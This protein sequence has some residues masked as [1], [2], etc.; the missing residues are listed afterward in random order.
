MG[1]TGLSMG[2]PNLQAPDQFGAGLDPAA[3]TEVL[4]AI[5]DLLRNCPACSSQEFADRRVTRKRP[6]SAD[7]SRALLS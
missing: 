7:A 2:Q 3:D 4:L 5:R 1:G 6:A